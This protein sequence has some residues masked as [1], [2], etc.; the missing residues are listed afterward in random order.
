MN[1]RGIVY[2]EFC[3]GRRNIM[4]E[5]IGMVIGNIIHSHNEKKEGNAY[6]IKDFFSHDGGVNPV[7]LINIGLQYFLWIEYRNLQKDLRAPI[8]D[9]SCKFV[10]VAPNAIPKGKLHCKHRKIH[11]QN[12]QKV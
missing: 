11:F 12:L 8:V 2:L 3:F 7:M 1:M 4:S 6:T 5:F 10:Y 9:I